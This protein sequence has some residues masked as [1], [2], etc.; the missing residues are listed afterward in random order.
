MRHHIVQ[1]ALAS[2]LAATPSAAQSS[3]TPGTSMGP[4]PGTPA[5]ATST[6]TRDAMARHMAMTPLRPANAADS[7]RAAQI[8]DRLRAAI[9]RYRD[10]KVAERDGFRMFLPNVKNQP[11]YHFTNYLWSVE[12]QFRFNPEKPTSLI[13]RPDG[14]GNLILLGAMYTAPKNATLDE[15]NAR[16]P[17]SV[18]QWHKHVN[19]CLPP[20]GERER[21]KETRNGQPVFGP[22][23][24]S[25]EAECKAVG[26]QFKKELLNWMA[27]ANVFESNDP[28]AIWNDDTMGGT[29]G[30]MGGMM[31]PVG[32][33]P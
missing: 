23:G 15:L 25:T 28:R 13:Y 1:F 21:W 4:T 16:V 33:Q 10:V 30:G 14:K 5:S 22:L 11:R 31:M 20:R 18:T 24:V 9:A 29:E 26:G 17:L 6:A 19:W 8:V 32:T 7:A 12:N 2:A 27:H 3:S